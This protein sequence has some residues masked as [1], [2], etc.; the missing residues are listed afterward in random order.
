MVSA[1]ELQDQLVSS[2]EKL[3][4]SVVAIDSMRLAR[5]RMNQVMPL[6]G[7]GTGVIID[8]NGYI[9]TNNH[10]VE[11]ASRVQIHVRDGRSFEGEVVGVDPA[12]DIALIRA[13]SDSNLPAAT[14]GDSDALKVGQFA[15]AIGNTLG[16]PGGSTAS[17]G[18]IGALGRP[19][20][21]AEFIFEGLIQ[22]DAAINPGNSGGPLADING[23]V[24]G[25]NT[26]MI[27]FAQGVGFAIPIN[28][29]KRVIQ[30]IFEKGRVIRPWLGISGVNLNPQIARR[31]NVETQ[32]GVL[33]A[34]VSREGPAYEAGLRQGDVIL[35]VGQTEIKQ[36]KDLL[37]A[38]SKLE[39]GSVMSLHYLRLGAR[40]Q[41]SLRL[42]EVPAEMQTYL[43]RQ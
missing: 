34:S 15:L 40:R 3:N 7:Q 11:G 29:V 26:A 1:I 21:W 5:T 20:P 31:Y 25:I 27:P 28:A 33:V 9:I 18:V 22:T 13:R 14:L 37:L 4:E 30:Q 38:M 23:H 6:E 10:V 32:T 39:V 42:S 19:L 35:Q 17:L 41:T 12:T 24:I 36:M 16:L 2:I 8:S 43:R